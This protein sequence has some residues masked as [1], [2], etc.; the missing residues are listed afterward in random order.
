MLRLI[1]KHDGMLRT[2]FTASSG[3]LWHCNELSDF[4]TGWKFLDQSIKF[5]LSGKDSAS[6]SQFVSCRPFLEY[7]ENLI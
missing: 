7:R 1:K 2:G 6:W 3:L 5:K 4:I